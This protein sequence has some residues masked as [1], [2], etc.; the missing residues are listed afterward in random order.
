MLTYPSPNFSIGAI[1]WVRPIHIFHV[2]GSRHLRFV[3]NRLGIYRQQWRVLNTKY[4]KSFHSW[5]FPVYVVVCRRCSLAYT[6]WIWWKALLPEYQR[7]RTVEGKWENKGCRERHVNTAVAVVFATRTMNRHQMRESINLGEPVTG[8]VVRQ[9]RP[10]VWLRA[11]IVLVW[12]KLKP[13]ILWMGCGLL[14]AGG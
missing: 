4:L 1:C 11:L 10:L 6:R 14:S 7:S 5:W 2:Y 8:Q 9:L 13:R 12:T 3:R